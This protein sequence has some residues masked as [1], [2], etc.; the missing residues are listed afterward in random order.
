MLLEGIADVCC[1]VHIK[2][3]AI[4]VEVILMGIARV[5]DFTEAVRNQYRAGLAD[6]A[7]VPIEQVIILVVVPG[8][9]VVKTAIVVPADAGLALVEEVK[10][11]LAPDDA[12]DTPILSEDVFGE[13]KATVRTL[14]P[15]PGHHVW[16]SPSCT[17]VPLASLLFALLYAA[18]K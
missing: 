5:E 3:F 9:I 16:R 8:S 15:Q 1:A 2:V 18:W 4:Q 13:A 7:G 11:R 14:N 6:R 17:A 12:D 10:G